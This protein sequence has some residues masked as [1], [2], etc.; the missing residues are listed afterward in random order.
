LA[1]HLLLENSM[2][3]A[4]ALVVMS[5]TGWVA[6]EAA[7]QVQAKGKTTPYVAISSL[8][9]T[10]R[11]FACDVAPIGNTCPGKAP[12]R[13][14]DWWLVSDIFATA[15]VVKFGTVKFAWGTPSQNTDD[16]PL[17]DLAGYRIFIRLQDCDTTAPN[18]PV[19]AY[20]TPIDTGLVN[21]FTVAGVAHEA[22][23]RIQARTV[24]GRFG[25]LTEPEVCG[26]KKSPETTPGIVPDV[27]AE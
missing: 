10:D 13:T 23:L 21:T 6:P 3:L 5:P 22:C 11:V 17:T 26:L 15:P 14:D 25:A 27:R 8:L 1:G 19:A 2:L 24:P 18:C 9:P 12:G 7:T 4:V 16:S 20:G